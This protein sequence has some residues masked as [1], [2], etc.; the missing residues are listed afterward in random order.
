MLLRSIGAQLDDEVVRA[1]KGD[2]VFVPKDA[3]HTFWNETDAA[4]EVLEIFTPA[5]LERWFGELAEIVASAS[6]DLNDIVESARRFGTELDLESIQPLMNA[7]G[8]RFP[9][10]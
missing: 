9:I 3:H 5:G 2:T 6:F 10:Q 8:L 4:S 1:H 7:H